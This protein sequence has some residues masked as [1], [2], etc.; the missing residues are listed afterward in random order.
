MRL[1]GRISLGVD[2]KEREW[3][4]SSSLTR[5]LATVWSFGLDNVDFA[6]YLNSRGTYEGKISFYVSNESNNIQ[7]ISKYRDNR[8]LNQIKLT[9]S[10]DVSKIFPPP[11]PLIPNY[12]TNNTDQSGTITRE[13]ITA[14]R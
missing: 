14:R 10:T 8:I 4:D 12:Y 11:P 1:N 6:N 3:L 9:L 13:A 7:N 2:S 5:Y